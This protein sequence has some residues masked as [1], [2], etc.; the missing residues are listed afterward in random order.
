MNRDRVSTLL[1]RAATP[2]VLLLAALLRTNWSYR[3]AFVDEAFN[4]FGGWQ[5]L[6]GIQ[7]YAMTFHMGW[8]VLSYIPLGLA[9][10]LR[11]VE[12]ARALNAVWGVL[13]IWMV[14]LTARQAYGKIAG[15]VAAGIFAVYAPAIVISTFATY[16][17]LSVFLAS[18]ALYLWTRGLARGSRYA[19]LFG[20]FFMTLA[21]LAKYT[22]VLV[23]ACCML[24]GLFVA[25][26]K[27]RVTVTRTEAG[28]VS[29]R[30]NSAAFQKLLLAAIP[31]LLLLV[32][33]FVYRQEL[34]QLW[35]SQVLTKESSDPNVRRAILKLTA[36]Y[37]WLPALLGLLAL[38]W[39]KKRIYSVGFG[40][41]PAAVLVYHLLNRDQTTLYKHTCYM[42]LGLA[43]L[44]GGGLAALRDWAGQ[45][46]RGILSL[47][48]AVVGIAAVAYLGVV[49]QSRL[50]GLRSY[51]SDTAQTM[52]YLRTHVAQGDTLLMEG[53]AVGEYYLIARGTPG[54]IPRRV[55]DTWWYVDEQG[56]GPEAFKRAISM[57]KFDWIVFD[58]VFTGDLDRELLTTMQDKYQLQA[59]FPARVFGK[60]GKIEVFKALP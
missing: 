34:M 39:R 59:T 51:W 21:V 43:P 42:L 40:L 49:G 57:N 41:L 17:S 36:E 19:F 24:Y 31:L 5:V 58:Y 2:L 10:W 50:P 27:A 52:A 6:Q 25:L 60:Y 56:S 33:A 45:R 54:H 16:D 32:Y 15:L 12:Y 46:M 8:Y 11:G 3:T 18:A 13:T 55:H 44:A 23:A 22:A 26:R 35:G 4:M 53:G 38:M 1:D 14:L 48:V 29:A 20:G 7:T 9:G 30:F 47:L 28:E 37:L